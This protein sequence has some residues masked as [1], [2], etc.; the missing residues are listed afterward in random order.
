MT[1]RIKLIFEEVFH[2]IEG[3]SAMIED[4]FSEDNIF[5]RD[6]MKYVYEWVHFD[7]TRPSEYDQTIRKSLK[8]W[9][10]EFKDQR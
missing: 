10:S 2:D 8:I 9:L 4:I 5:A 3:A 7:R 1:D 6:E